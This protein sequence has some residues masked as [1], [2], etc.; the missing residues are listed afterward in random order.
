MMTACLNGQLLGSQARRPQAYRIHG[1]INE[2][3]RASPVPI[4]VPLGC[5]CAKRERT[6]G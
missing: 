6:E 5:C 4:G 2:L 1:L 3:Q